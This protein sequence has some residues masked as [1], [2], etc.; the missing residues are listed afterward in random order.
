MNIDCWLTNTK[1]K[2]NQ[3]YLLKQTN[4]QLLL[5]IHKVGMRLIFIHVTVQHTVILH[6]NVII[7]ILLIFL[8]WSV[9]KTAQ[10]S[11]KIFLKT[12]I[13]MDGAKLNSHDSGSHFWK[14]TFKNGCWKKIKISAFFFEKKKIW[15]MRLKLSGAP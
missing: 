14:S 6:Q 15:G 10:T 13:M 3:K 4:Y 12:R 5:S 8:Y 1:R 11:F 7:Y 2:K 9:Q